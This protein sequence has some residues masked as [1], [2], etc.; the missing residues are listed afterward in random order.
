MYN[1]FIAGNQIQF[2]LINTQDTIVVLYV[3]VLSE[4]ISEHSDSAIH[5]FI[6]KLLTF[7]WS[8]LEVQCT[9]WPDDKQFC[10]ISEYVDVCKEAAMT[11]SNQSKLKIDK[12]SE[13]WITIRWQG[14]IRV[15]IMMLILQ[16]R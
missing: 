15:T 12:N 1:S 4:H 14:Y 16:K 13:V 3:T 10:I 6:T 2:L 11:E 5:K 9:C 7:L 8:P